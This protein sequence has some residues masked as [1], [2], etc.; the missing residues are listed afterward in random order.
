M[1]NMSGLAISLKKV[2]SRAAKHL[3]WVMTFPG[4]KVKGSTRVAIDPSTLR[5]LGLILFHSDSPVKI[6]GKQLQ[7]IAARALA[8]D[9][10]DSESSKGQ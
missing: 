6:Q 5:G 9:T 10:D 7:K 8:F 4:R 1:V 3:S 2:V